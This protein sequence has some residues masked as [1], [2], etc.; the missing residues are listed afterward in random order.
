MTYE[1]A[2]NENYELVKKHSN[3]FS[4]NA[5]DISVLPGWIPLVDGLL[6][7][8]QDNLKENERLQIVQIKEKFG[9]LRINFG[10]NGVNEDRV[11]I[12]RDIV[13][14]AENKSMKLCVFCGED[15]LMVNRGWISPRCTEH[16]STDFDLADRAIVVL[17][18]HE[19]RMAK[20][21]KQK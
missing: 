17:A 18:K 5:Y 10:T 15:G 7:C 11:G 16:L 8:I 6:S 3:L 21:L 20:L 14:D 19:D 4:V 9:Q 13:K 12:F 2:L 1:Q